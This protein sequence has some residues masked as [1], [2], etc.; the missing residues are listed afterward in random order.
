MN[1]T[2][3]QILPN[4]RMKLA[5]LK[6]NERDTYDQI[7]NKL[8]ELIPE[9]DDEGRYTQEFRLGLLNARL[10]LKHGKVITHE[11]LKKKLGLK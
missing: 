10:E 11:E 2:S 1:Y 8:L 3:I 4:T 5:K 9:G 6:S 7:I